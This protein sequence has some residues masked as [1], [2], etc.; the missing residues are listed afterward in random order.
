[1]FGLYIALY[2][3]YCGSSSVSMWK[4]VC[5]GFVT[6]KDITNSS[7]NCYIIGLSASAAH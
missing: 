3:S 6:W 1:M 5:F 7:T 2:I 4:G